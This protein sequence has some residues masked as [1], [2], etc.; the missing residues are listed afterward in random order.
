MSRSSQHAVC[1]WLFSIVA[2]GAVALAPSAQ[3]QAFNACAPQGTSTPT[4]DGNIE[5][6][7]DE[8]G[9]LRPTDTGWPASARIALKDGQGVTRDASIWITT[10]A[11]HLYVGGI[12]DNP[13]GNDDYGALTPDDTIVI[14]LSAT[15]GT[16]PS[17]WGIVIQPNDSDSSS[18]YAVNRHLRIFDPSNLDAGYSRIDFWRTGNWSGDKTSVQIHQGGWLELSSNFAYART[19]SKWSFEMRVPRVASAAA[20]GINSGVFIGGADSTFRLYFNV[21]STNQPG[22]EYFEQYPWPGDKGIVPNGLPIESVARPS[23]EWGVV[24]FESPSPAACG[25]IQVDANNIGVI[26]PDGTLDNNV[27]CRTSG[28]PPINRVAARLDN[29]GGH[30]KVQVKFSSAVWG[31]QGGW[32]QDWQDIVSP[33]AAYP[34]PAIGDVPA[35]S[36]KDIESRWSVPSSSTCNPATSHPCLQAHFT[37]IEGTTP[38]SQSSAWRNMVWRVASRLDEPAAIQAPDVKRANLIGYPNKMLIKRTSQVIKQQFEDAMIPKG[39]RPTRCSAAD[40]AAKT[41]ICSCLNAIRERPDFQEWALQSDVSAR[42]GFEAQPNRNP[43]FDSALPRAA[44]DKLGMSPAELF[45]QPASQLKERLQAAKLGIPACQGGLDAPSVPRRRWET[46]LL[47]TRGYSPTKRCMP[48][49][50]HRYCEA[51]PLGAYAYYVRHFL[52]RK[53]AADAAVAV[54]WKPTLKAPDGFTG[55]KMSAQRGTLAGAGLKMGVVEP[56]V[57]VYEL[58]LPAG[59]TV[60]LM[61]T[62]EATEAEPCTLVFGR[63]NCCRCALGTGLDDDSDGNHRWLLAAVFLALIVH[64]RRHRN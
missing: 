62:V 21:L 55:F 15:D 12:I 14:G 36:R 52:E 60:S 53:T 27:A 38:L 3:A 37:V 56:A 13:R 32:L 35:G 4:I 50:K 30:A 28:T 9:A 40:P 23:S 1:K 33:D 46:L 48:I 25:T 42:P 61:N 10:T 45:N 20:A 2:A 59:K 26:Q 47:T 29:K 39:H 24:S 64:R 18:Q 6:L 51:A 31:I 11:T 54:D 63:I 16:T 8:S 57:E 22:T 17:E 58:D 5:G 19:P 7:L 43:T 41:P 34:N 44:W 49:G